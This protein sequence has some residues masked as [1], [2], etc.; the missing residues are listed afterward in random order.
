MMITNTATFIKRFITTAG[1]SLGFCSIA[2]SSEN[3]EVV[4]I[5][6]HVLFN[7]PQVVDGA[8]ILIRDRIENS[9]TA[10]ISSCALEPDTAYS[11][12]WAV[13]NEPR[14]CAQPYDCM[15]S[16]LEVF[17]GDSK[18]KASVFWGG[19]FVSDQSGVVNTSLRLAPGST[20][21]E[22][23][24]QSENYGLQNLL[25]SEIHVVMRT[26][27]PAGVA[28][29]IAEQIGTANMACPPDGCQNVFA[30]IHQAAPGGDP[31]TD[32]CDYSASDV[33]D[34]WGWDPVLAQ[35]CLPRN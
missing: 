11:I 27:G 33:N 14:F 29:S 1:I 20:D 8:T 7:T 17:G 13:F 4:N 34:G 25:G 30:S 18:V 12:W 22:L 31:A 35:S 16:D 23:F 28:G 10:T 5:S 2:L 15:V 9:I 32:N 24:A 21:R 3:R 19:G 26:H 6:D